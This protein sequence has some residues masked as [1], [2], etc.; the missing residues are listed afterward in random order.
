M[1]VGIEILKELREHDATCNIPVL[2]LTS[3]EVEIARSTLPNLGAN[4]FLQ[5][6][7]SANELNRRQFN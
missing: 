3:T 6:P 7:V 4:D 1:P 5:K 2:A